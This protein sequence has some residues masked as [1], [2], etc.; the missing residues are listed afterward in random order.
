[1]DVQSAP[2]SSV[3]VFFITSQTNIPDAP[4]TSVKT[5]QTGKRSERTSEDLTE[6]LS[7]VSKTTT[8]MS[9]IRP[10]IQKLWKVV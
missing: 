9:Y 4:N 3:K 7:L 5:K 1:M 8:A 2:R 6:P 10:V